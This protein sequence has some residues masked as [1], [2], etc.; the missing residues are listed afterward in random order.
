VGKVEE[1]SKG[2][3]REITTRWVRIFVALYSFDGPLSQDMCP[4]FIII[5]QLI[6]GFP[7]GVFPRV[8]TQIYC[9]MCM[10]SIFMLSLI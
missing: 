3:S 7:F 9:A 6:Y 5:N 10:V 2:A 1:R 4:R 8:F